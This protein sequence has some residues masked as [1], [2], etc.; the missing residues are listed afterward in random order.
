M[1]GNY[2]NLLYIYLQTLHRVLSI[3]MLYDDVISRPARFALIYAKT[4][5]V[6]A[7]SA[8]FSGNMGPVYGTLISVGI[9]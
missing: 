5:L 1:G 6:L 7:L 9:G 8:L 3:L 2:G 4:I